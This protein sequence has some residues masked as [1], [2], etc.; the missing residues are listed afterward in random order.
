MLGVAQALAIVFFGAEM[1]TAVALLILL[2]FLLIRPSG[3]FGKGS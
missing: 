1:K 2:A 3:L